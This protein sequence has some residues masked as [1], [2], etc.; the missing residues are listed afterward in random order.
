MSSG[1]YW[2][3]SRVGISLPWKSCGCRCRKA[4]RGR[5]DGVPVRIALIGFM[6]SGKTTIGRLL[7]GSFACAFFDLDEEIA[8]S[9]GLSPAEIFRASGEAEFRRLESA[10]LRLSSEISDPMV[11][12]CGGGVVGAA[13][14]RRILREKFVAV[15]IDVPFEEI[16]RRLSVCAGNRPL[17]SSAGADGQTGHDLNQKNEAL[18]RARLPLYRECASLCYRWQPSETPETSAAIIGRLLHSRTSS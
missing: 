13:E 15:W 2:H 14:N 17:W 11:L 4:H 18:Y 5:Q 10:A 1:T 16:Y 6:G 8:K 3:E 9:A 12:A 7:A